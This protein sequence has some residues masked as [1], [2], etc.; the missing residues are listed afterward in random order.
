[1]QSEKDIRET[2]PGISAIPEFEGAHDKVL[3]YVF[4]MHDYDSP[5]WGI[6]FRS[7]KYRVMR[8]LG[9]NTEPSANVFLN[10]HKEDLKKAEDYFIGMRKE[11]MEKMVIQSFDEQL[12]EWSKL[13]SKKNKTSEQKA[14]VLKVMPQIKNLMAQ[15]EGLI[16]KVRNRYEDLVDDSSDV[17]GEKI[18]KTALEIANESE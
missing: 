6:P 1:M 3:K 17:S 11:D 10:R 12:E 13:L 15:R 5:F 2:N 7:R 16:E 9:Y 14:E 8:A 18:P 4:L